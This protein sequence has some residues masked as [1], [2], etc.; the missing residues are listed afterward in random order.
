[1][2]PDSVSKAMA[3]GAIEDETSTEQI[4]ELDKRRCLQV[5]GR[6]AFLFLLDSVE[7]GS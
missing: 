4:C 2:R 7:L 3:S 1:M 6:N 5:S